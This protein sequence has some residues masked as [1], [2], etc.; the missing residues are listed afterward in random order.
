MRNRTFTFAQFI[1]ILYL[2]SEISSKFE[3]TNLKCST[4][5]EQFSDFE[6]CY[7]KSVNRSYKY[8]SINLI[9]FK[10]FNGYR[11]F[12]YN[13]TADACRFLR[14]LNLNP[15]LKYFYRFV[16]LYSNMNHTCPFD[17]D[18]QFEKI[19]ADFVNDYMTRVLPFP[20]GDYMLEVSWI[21]Y[22]IKRATTQ[23]YGTIS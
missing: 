10:R 22:D 19:P 15:A 16:E 23:F 5:D 18:V 2:V 6:Y 9:L 12:M 13:I 11:P 17:H 14:G 21:A 8:I 4:F 3:F 1:V 20:H 7:I